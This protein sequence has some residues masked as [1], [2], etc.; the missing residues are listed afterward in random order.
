VTSPPRD[1]QLALVRQQVRRARPK[2]PEG[3]A[4][5]RPVARVVVDLGLAH[6]D[7]PFDYLVP[8]SLD[9]A[10]Q[11]GVRVRVRFAGQLVGGFLLDRLEAS[12]HGGRLAR[13]E[14]V[15]SPEPVLSPVIAALARDVADRYAG[16]LSDVL[17]LAV[18]PRHARV[19]AETPTPPV[20]GEP[21][22]AHPGP[23]GWDRYTAGPAFLRALAAGSAP[24]AVWTALP[25][26]SWPDEIALAV[27]SALTAGRGSLVVVP[28]HRDIVRVADAIEAA[29]GPGRHVVLTAELGPA[30]RYRRW[31][32]VR[33]GQVRTVVGTRA[34]MFAPVAG[35]G[36]VAVWDD[37]DDLH[38]EPHAPYPH[39]REVLA[40]RAER[41]SAALL[42]GGLARTAEAELLVESGRAHPVQPS[43]DQ[44]RATAPLVRAAGG[45]AELARDPAARTA[46]LPTLAWEAASTGLASGPVL[47][48]VPRRGYVPSL[49]CI[50]CH[51]PARCSHCSGPLALPSRQGLTACRWC[52]RTAGGW[53][54]PECDGS[55]FRAV[56]VGAARTAEELGRAFPGVPVRTSG[57]DAVL[58]TVGAEP[59][60]VVATPGAEPVAD[61][62]YAAALL[63]DGWA[64]LARPDLRAEEETLRR[65]LTASALVRPAGEGGRVIVLAEGSLTPVQALLRWDPAGAAARELGERSRLGFP[66]AVRL[67]ALVGTASA[68][69]DLL[70]SAPLPRSAQVLGPQ[71]FEGATRDGDALVRAL[72]RVPLA[73]GPELTAALKAGQ[74]VR[75]ARKAT[76]FVTVR[77][78]PAE[79]G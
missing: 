45:D 21:R 71:P 9:E 43:R 26:P 18:P 44:L 51:A 69:S 73:E 36:L 16:T 2:P 24:A 28:D 53:R 58:A 57:R 37:G 23:G 15:V 79:L 75:S 63:L 22:S 3:V 67:A 62:G 56:V 49:A 38:G 41:E 6:L 68:V 35:L 5:E 48:Q 31:L 42:V 1:E 33:R 11:P 50:D 70:G 29:C 77:V 12:E 72:V 66:P 13:L 60:L 54:C 47:V 39:V 7:R 17:R 27:R 64:L 76:D 52:G 32:A 30:E 8:T 59:A 4:V 78:D 14:R 40:M 34:A 65:W 61:G 74:S 55:R 25:G 10:A 19:E 20:A 46:R